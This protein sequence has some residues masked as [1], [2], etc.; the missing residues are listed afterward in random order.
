MKKKIL[1]AISFLTGAA[2]T[3]AA[4]NIFGDPSK[5]LDEIKS[6][7][8]YVI[9]GVFIVSGLFNLG[10]FFGENRDYKKGIYNVVGYVVGVT[11]FLAV[12]TYLTSLS[13]S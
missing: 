1:L 6:Y 2:Q 10:N 4:T 9:V 8:P 3:Y 12:V 13:I 11:I 7:A 5:F